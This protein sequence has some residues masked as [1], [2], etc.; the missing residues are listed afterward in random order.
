[1]E[2]VKRECAISLI[3]GASDGP[4][5]RLV[6]IAQDF[7]LK[8]GSLVLGDSAAV[9]QTVQRQRG[10][11]DLRQIPVFDAVLEVFLQRIPVMI[12]AE[13]SSAVNQ[14]FE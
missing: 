7:I 9:Y 3:F 11:D 6:E 2:E 10:L 8:S 4:K 12:H 14:T 5:R 13:H 1:M